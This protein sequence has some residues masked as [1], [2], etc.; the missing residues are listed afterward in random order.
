MGNSTWSINLGCWSGVYVRLHVTLALVM[1]C[2]LLLC[3]LTGIYPRASFPVDRVV[4]I[5]LLGLASVGAHAASHVISA[6]RQGIE[7]QELMLAPWGEWSGVGSHSPETPL[8]VHLVGIVTNVFLCA[9]SAMVL[10]LH[11]DTSISEMLIPLDSKLL[12]Q[13]EHPLIAFRWLFCIN[14]CL[15][16]MNL[17]PAAPFDGSR[18]LKSL[19]HIA[20]PRMPRESVNEC[21]SVTG[22][23]M[24]GVLIALAA[25]LEIGDKGGLF[26]AWFPV[27]VL[28]LI[29]LF[30]VEPPAPPAAAAEAPK[31]PPVPGE[32]RDEADLES[33]LSSDPIDWE[34]GPFAQWLEEKR[35]L[36]RARREEVRQGEIA[37]ERKVDEILARL[38][39]R[40]PQAI[41]V[42]DRQV[43][44][45]V[46]DRLRRRKQKK[47]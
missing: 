33:E 44:Q 18:I 22:R 36:E 35:D 26:P 24:G 8:Q 15:V 41:S 43:L 17:I 47:S 31:A 13:E 30:A 6:A 16:V 4:L 10:W 5:M 39:E 28:G 12:L 20:L 1:L 29:A 11:G 32:L 34:D 21:V 38:H 40:G 3:D 19:L 23:V 9:T 46:S 27:T 37:D 14:Y 25:W 42:E 7:T 2:A 45:R